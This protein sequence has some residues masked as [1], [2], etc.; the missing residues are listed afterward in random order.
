M[1]CY[2]SCGSG[3]AAGTVTHCICSLQNDNHQLSS[4]DAH[5]PRCSYGCILVCS[6]ILQ[7]LPTARNNTIYLSRS[8]GGGQRSSSVFLGLLSLFYFSFSASSK[9]DEHRLTEYTK[10]WIPNQ[11]SAMSTLCCKS[12]QLSQQDPS[13]SGGAVWQLITSISTSESWK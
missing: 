4:Y 11:F 2:Y 1:P 7:W 13:F 8:Q 3:R 5:T 10:L 9:W 6:F 12:S